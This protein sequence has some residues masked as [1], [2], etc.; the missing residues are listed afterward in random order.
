MSDV[1]FV[2]KFE[3]ICRL[4]DGNVYSLGLFTSYEEADDASILKASV[5]LPEDCVV[6]YEI[7]KVRIN[8]P[9]WNSMGGS[10]G[11][12]NRKPIC[13]E[14]GLRPALR[15]GSLFHLIPAGSI[16]GT[17]GGLESLPDS[18]RACAV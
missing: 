17:N 14:L 15:G 3:V 1:Q 6:C 7:H 10:K 9:V 11:G 13:L 12:I 16:S 18:G 2:D 5:K 4:T 8:L